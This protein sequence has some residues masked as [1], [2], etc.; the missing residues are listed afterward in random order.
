MT[1]HPPNSAMRGS[2]RRQFIKQALATGAAL[3]ASSALLGLSACTTGAPTGPAAAGGK[4]AKQAI[5]DIDGGRVVDPNLWNPWPPGH[6]RDH[7][8]HQ[9]VIE[10]LFILNYESGKMEPWLAESMTSNSK[11]DLWTLKLRDGVKW[12]DGEDFNADD[13]V[14]TIEMLKEN[15][16]DLVGGTGGDSS[17]MD[18]WVKSVKKLDDLTVEFNLKKPNPRFQ[19]DYFGVRIYGSVIMVPEHIWKDQDPLTFKNFDLDRGWP[20]FTGPY[21]VVSVSP[22]EFVYE[23]ND[24]WWGAQAGFQELPA[25]QE[26]IWIW[27][28]PE[29]TRASKMAEGE[30]DSLMD[31]TLGAFEALRQRNPN[32]IAWLDELPFAWLDPCERNLELNHT[33]EPWGDKEMR[34]ALN[35]AIDRDQIVK[36]AY[37]GTTFPSDHIFPAYDPLTRLIDMAKKEGLYDTFPVMETNPQKAKQIIEGKGYTRNGNGYYEKDGKELSLDIENNEAYI[38]KQRIAQV[39]VENLQ[40]L[41][42]NATTRNIAG[43]TWEENYALG[44]FEARTGWQTC[45]SV[46]EPWA[47]LD[48]LSSRWYQPVGK[49]ANFNGWRWRNEKFSSVVDEMGSLPLGDPKVDEL[50]LEAWEVFL[51]ELPVIPITQAKKLIPFDTTYWKGWPTAENNYMHPPTWWNSTHKIIHALEA[52]EG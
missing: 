23:R 48:T 3:P 19:L 38:E 15:A 22:T 18:T 14:F 42:I 5:F 24:D 4:R 43:T 33:V 12:S 45:G 29:E 30:L 49:R 37:E 16:P 11:L 34:W 26:L 2:T 17:A 1:E 36:I 51:D 44:K 8:F 25:P 28:G 6:R 32:V 46:N 41:G 52:A 31:I 39:V 21:R 13:V 35:Y 9:A 10:P 20:V 40:A 7:G 50:F 27:A 47:S